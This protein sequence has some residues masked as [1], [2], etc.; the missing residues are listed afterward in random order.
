MVKKKADS[1]KFPKELRDQLRTGRT[2]G[3]S[4]MVYEALDDE[5]PMDVNEILIAI[6]T[7]HKVVM[8]RSSVLSSLN[9][10]S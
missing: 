6:W 5:T 3:V 9:Y 10:M 8:K 7:D 1:S 4:D 2:S